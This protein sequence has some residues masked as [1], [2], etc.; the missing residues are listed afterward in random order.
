MVNN[1]YQSIPPNT[2]KTFLLTHY[3]RFQLKATAF[4]C[5]SIL[6]LTIM[7]LFHQILFNLASLNLTYPFCNFD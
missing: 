3:F 6:E 2:Y 1:N 4:I 7:V 5:F